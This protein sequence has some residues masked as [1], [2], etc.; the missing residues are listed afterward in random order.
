MSKRPRIVILSDGIQGGAASLAN[1]LA[2]D[3]AAAVGN[4]EI[5]RWH[6]SPYS[7]AG[8][9]HDRVQETSLAPQLKR[10][11]VERLLKNIYRNLADR[12]RA[13]RNDRALL[14]AV[15]RFSP[16][17]L[18]VHNI[19]SADLSHKTLL[20]L[21]K[22]LP[23]VWTLHDLWPL[24]GH[25][26]SWWDFRT[27]KRERHLIGPSSRKNLI[28][29][30]D[31]F[32]SS[33]RNITMVSPS[34][35]V[36]NIVR[37]YALRYQF[38]T[39]T[40]PHVVRDEFFVEQDRLLARNKWQL[41]PGKLW[42]GIGSTWNNNRKGMDVFWDALRYVDISKLGLLIWGQQPQVP[43]SLGLESRCVGS[44]SSA[45]EM[46]SLFA[47]VDLFVC[48]TKGDTG[49]LTVLE[50]MAVETPVLAS[51]VGGIPERIS[52]GL[53]GLLFESQNER[54][55]ADMINQSSSGLWPLQ[56]MG[57]A[58]RMSVIGKHASKMQTAQYTELYRKRIAWN[59]S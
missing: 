2:N 18:H 52:H 13:R 5:L 8:T 10:P 59:N 57:L 11:P 16:D 27:Q 37:P 55:L 35:Y 32:F 46:A 17:L 3:L 38:K 48:P 42:I 28:S 7:R 49:P 14:Q 40:I 15:S 53:N 56:K 9:F 36:A 44:I 50:S 25:A 22:S 45:V 6:F 58:A 19:H 23:L 41:T 21:P 43:E 31:D 24:K 39:A 54:N 29:Q 47:A 34:Q 12:L 4:Y 26:T 20:R 30:R 33:G 1:M 51:R